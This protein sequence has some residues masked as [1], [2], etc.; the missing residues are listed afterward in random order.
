M[1]VGDLETETSSGSD[2][3]QSLPK[4]KNSIS[5]KEGLKCASKPSGEIK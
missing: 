1:Y 2:T 5:K 3:D 4:Q